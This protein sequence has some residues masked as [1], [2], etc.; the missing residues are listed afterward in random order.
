[1]S[2]KKIK[3]EHYPAQLSAL[4]LTTGYHLSNYHASPEMRLKEKVDSILRC[5]K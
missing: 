5:D 1:M 2:L 4:F 3:L